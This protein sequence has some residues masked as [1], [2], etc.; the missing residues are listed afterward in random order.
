MNYS[1]KIKIQKEVISDYNY[2]YNHLIRFL[3]ETS[4]YID[5][6]N[7][8]DVGCGVG[9]LSLYIASKRKKVIGIDIS[10]NAIAIAQKSAKFLNLDNCI[11]FINKDILDYNTN[12]KFDFILCSEVIEHNKNVLLMLKKIKTFMKKDGVLFVT[13]PLDT[14]PLYRW[15]LLHKFELR[16]GHIKRY[17]EKSIKKLIYKSGL[18][19]NKISFEEGVLRNLLFTNRVFNLLIKLLNNS[20][21]MSYCFSTIDNVF[22]IIFGPSNI[23]LILKKK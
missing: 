4:G 20:Q 9:T 19:I 8:L 14:A 15:G 18:E 11:K 12:F 2:T 16:V 6:K 21:I 13:T 22:K 10:K 1:N 17:S 23:F 7:I 5:S 3:N